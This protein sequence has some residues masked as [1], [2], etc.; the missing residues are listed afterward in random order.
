MIKQE[1]ELFGILKEGD[2]GMNKE[3]RKIVDLMNDV[4]IAALES[5]ST[6]DYDKYIANVN[7]RIGNI[8]KSLALLKRELTNQ[9][10]NDW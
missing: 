7:E 3:L 1:V 6:E 2:V 9:D 4:Q 10:L 5:V 8:E